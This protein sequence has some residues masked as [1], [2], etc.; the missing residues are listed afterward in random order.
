MTIETGVGGTA[1]DFAGWV[2]QLHVE[3]STL[4]VSVGGKLLRGKARGTG[5]F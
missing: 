1:V 4:G 3:I 5:G 2:A